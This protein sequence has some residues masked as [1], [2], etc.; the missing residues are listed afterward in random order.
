MLL[1]FIV[2]IVLAFVVLTIILRR[3]RRKRMYEIVGE[4]ERERDRLRRILFD[5]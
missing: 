2:P 4:L 3:A 5:D 1:E